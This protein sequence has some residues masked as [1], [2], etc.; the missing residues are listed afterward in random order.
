MIRNTTDR[1]TN[2]PRLRLDLNLGTIHIL[3]DWSNGP[4]GSNEEIFAAARDA[5]Y[6]GVQGEAELAE[7]AHRLGLGITS[8]GRVDKPEDADSL[9][10]RMKDAGT[11]ACTLHVGTGFEDDRQ[12]DALMD[13]II[14]ASTKHDYP[15]YVETHRAT[16]TQDCYRTLKLIERH[17]DL[18]LNGDFSHW[19]TGLEMVY[20]DFDHKLINLQPVF[21]R[22]RFIHGRIG[23]P[24]CMQV[25][26]GDG[27]T[28]GR[29]Y[30]QHFR[31]MWQM[32][33]AA[34]RKSAKNGD[35]I[36]FAPELLPPSIFYART[37]KGHEES[38]RWEQALVLA[39]IAREC[40]AEV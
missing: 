13:A 7:M 17:P 6:G 37:F 39:R 29:T 32:S 3:P 15:L 40:F 8:S 28:K 19:Y 2:A 24:G 31:Q 23:N 20:G 10:K 5:G 1:S 14:N 25:D 26:I 4:R 9:A 16:L 22:V 11:D 35:M 30:V 27:Q 33:F 21:D 38:D 18:R 12:A 34:F 36:V